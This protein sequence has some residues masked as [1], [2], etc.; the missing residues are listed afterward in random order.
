[1]ASRESDGASRPT[2]NRQ[3]LDLCQWLDYK[4]SV[5]YNL[6]K[7]YSREWPLQQHAIGKIL[8]IFMKLRTNPPVR[9]GNGY[10]SHCRPGQSERSGA[11][12]PFHCITIRLPMNPLTAFPWFVFLLVCGLL[13]APSRA[14]EPAKDHVAS[15][16]PPRLAPDPDPMNRWLDEVRA[17]R[18]A[19]QERRRVTKE[20]IDARRRWIDPWGAAQHQ[21]REKETQRRREAFHDQIARERQAFREQGPWFVPPVPGEEPEAQ[22]NTLDFPAYPPLPGWDNRWYYRGY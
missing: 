6:L 4:I 5:D 3:R 22:A 1:M 18:Q 15:E 9:F 8:L 20:A 13:D 7:F 17:Q 21:A 19:W 16:T 10:R 14:M 12:S 2:A 11:A